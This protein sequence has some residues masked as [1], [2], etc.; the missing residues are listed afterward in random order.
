SGGRGWRGGAV[1]GWGAAGG[2]AR[3]ATGGATS[4]WRSTWLALGW[5]GGWGWG[6]VSASCPDG[7]S[8][9]AYVSNCS[10]WGAGRAAAFERNRKSSRDALKASTAPPARS[11]GATRGSGGRA[12]TLTGRGAGC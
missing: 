10:G 1:G 8:A 9:R 4:A 6:S 3:R 5:G 2:A 11:S 7:A 12:S